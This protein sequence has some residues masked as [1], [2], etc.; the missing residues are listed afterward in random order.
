MLMRLIADW[1]EMLQEQVEYRELLFQMVKRDL[2]LRY[3][4]TA[5]G[6]GWAIFMPLVNTVVFTVIFTKV[7]DLKTPVAYPVYAYCGLWVWNFFASSLRFAVVSLTGNAN[8]VGKVYFPREIFPFTAILV[9]FV[10]FIVAGTV[11]A[12]LMIYYQV[13]PTWSILMLPGVAAVH[14]AITAAVALLVSLANLF[15]RDV[16]YL[17]ELVLSVW[18]FLSS[19]LYPLDRVEGTLGTIMRLNPMTAIIDGY[20]ACLLGIPMSDPVGLGVAGVVSV[21]LLIASWLIFHRAEFA[22]AENV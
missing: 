5:M 11:L 16:K 12:A 14:L 18:M 21:V 7:A 22:F 3:K 4:Q 10:D 8:L 6:F 9:S 17:F 15:Y 20:R 2:L 1:R 19:A 13:A